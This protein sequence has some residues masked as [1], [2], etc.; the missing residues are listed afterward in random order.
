MII[1]ISCRVWKKL[2]ILYIKHDYV[3]D[4]A[5]MGGEGEEKRE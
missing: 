3:A 2:G 1:Q 4:T 5:M